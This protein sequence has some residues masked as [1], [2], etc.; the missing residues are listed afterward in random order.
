MLKKER[1]NV[2]LNKKVWG[3]LFFASIFIFLFGVKEYSEYKKDEE[4][5]V[6]RLLNKIN[7]KIELF[8]SSIVDLENTEPIKE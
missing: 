2:I 4:L 6:E 7:L 1:K 3:F 8:K 5:R